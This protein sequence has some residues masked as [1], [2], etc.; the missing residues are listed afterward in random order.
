MVDR[1]KDKVAIITGG[2]TGIGK[3]IAKIFISEGAKVV[4]AARNEKMLQDTAKEIGGGNILAVRCDV[5]SAADVKNLINETVSRFS[6]LNILVNNAGK[7]PE[8]K[9]TLEDTTEEEW[10]EYQAVNAKG[11][12]LCSKYAIPEIRKAGGGSII[13]IASIS[14]H[15]G[16]EN[17]GP[18]NSSKAAQEGL[19]RSMAMDFSRDKIR[20]NAISPGWVMVESMREAREKIMDY[21]KS[22]HPIGRI[23]YPEDIAWAAV[24]LASDESTWVTGA[25]FAIDGGYLAK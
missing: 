1:L 13:M 18:Y 22:L 7:N 17:V 5:K 24:Y 6:K 23:G 12:F 15:I 9:F 21:I 10:D 4:I 14:A 11:S 20:V 2:D 25:T 16:Q 3:G 8:R 19:I